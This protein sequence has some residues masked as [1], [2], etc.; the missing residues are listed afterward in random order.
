MAIPRERRLR[1]LLQVLPV[2]DASPV[3]EPPRGYWD[4][5][6]LRLGRGH[7]FDPHARHYPVDH[8][9]LMEALLS[10]AA[11]GLDGARFTQVLPGQPDVA[12]VGATAFCAEEDGQGRAHRYTLRLTHGGRRFGVTFDDRSEYYNLNALLALLN[13]ALEPLDTPLRF[14]GVGDV[15]LLGPLEGLQQAL[16]EGF[17]PGFEGEGTLEAG[18]LDAIDA[19]CESGDT[20]ESLAR[21]LD[22]GRRQVHVVPVA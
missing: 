17:I 12:W 13:A 2:A 22:K 1:E 20:P 9:P 6:F 7:G 18:E 15:V 16:R 4:E 19:W 5:P 11:P 21:Q 3:E 14:F 10:L 8:S